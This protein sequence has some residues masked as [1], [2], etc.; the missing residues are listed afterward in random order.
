VDDLVD[1][2]P[3]SRDAAYPG[4]ETGAA[5]VH[6]RRK[7]GPPPAWRPFD[8]LIALGLALLVLPA[9]LLPERTWAPI[10]R[11]LARLP[12]VTNQRQLRRRASDIAAALNLTDRHHAV[13]IARDLKAAVYEMRMQDL[14]AWRPGGWHPKIA[15]EGE[16]HLKA[17]LA[18][19]K[20]AVLWVAPFAFNSG[21]PKIALSGLSYQVSHLSSPTHGYSDTRFGIR[22]L[23]RIRCIPEDRFIAER[24]V[25][26]KAA[27]A[28]AMRRMMRTLQ[29]GRI[30]SIVAASTEGYEMVETPFLGG[31]LP[32]AV[33]APRLAALTG[34]PLLP[35]FTP[36]D[37][38]RGFRIV[39]EPPIDLGPEPKGD[40]RS[41]AAAVAF[42]RRAEP[43]V[44]EFPEQWRSWSKWRPK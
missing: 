12:L 9:W 39:I 41:I 3:E 14:R 17:A 32:V 30:V 15:V 21:A 31:S 40:A 29:A 19:G 44:R 38:K 13:R 5:I 16:A 11:G 10:W 37:P 1:S 43:W 7:L 34:A 26:D 20:G 42:F 4:N 22:V 2:R 27:P 24:I 8:L 28:S 33:G 25:F 23:N 18:G 35:V 6:K 36:R